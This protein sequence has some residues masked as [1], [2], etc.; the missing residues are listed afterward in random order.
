MKK[1]VITGGNGYIASLVKEALQSSM[2]IISLT[3]KELDLGDTDAVR[4]W[5]KSHDY[6]YVFHTGAMAQTADCEKYPELTHRINVDCTKEIA[7][8]CKEKNARL[9]FISTEQCFNGKTEEGPFTEDTSLCSVT[10]YG[11]HKV[12]CE[13]FITSSLEDYIILRFSWMLG[14]SR[15]G[16]KASP[17]IIRN[18]MNAMFY[19]APAKFTVNE[20]RGMTY[21]QKLAD[22][23][24]K[25]IELPS[26]IYHVSDTNTH[27]TYESAK[28][29]AQ[30]LGF[31]Q[32]QIDA[33]ILPNHERYADRFRDYRLDTRKLKAHGIDFGTF[34][35]NV[36]A[37]LKDFGWLK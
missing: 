29:V 31:T 20:I 5:F 28:I 37:C 34:E 36:D 10:A 26:G 15:P 19:Q 14:M 32:E 33:C 13:D 4:S 2:E 3:R 25:I 22:V 17:N 6:D 18:V 35:E 12:E 23:F 1:I 16:I 9:I 24:D 11:N 21:A 30:K 8:A 7:T 27:N